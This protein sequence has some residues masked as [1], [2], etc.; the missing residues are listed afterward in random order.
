MLRRL[1]QTDV[2][3]S[4]LRARISVVVEIIEYACV[5]RRRVGSGVDERRADEE[6]QTV[7]SNRG[8]DI[9]V[10]TGGDA[11]GPIAGIYVGYAGTVGSVVN[12]AG[13]VPK[14]IVH[15]NLPDAARQIPGDVVRL[16]PGSAGNHA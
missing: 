1:V 10:L 14:I 5:V 7:G 13:G 6:V 2:R 4:A 12:L 8:G 11:V 15:E 3:C 16:G 9:E